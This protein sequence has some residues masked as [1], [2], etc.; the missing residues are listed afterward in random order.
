MLKFR[1][2]QVTTV[3]YEK[4]TMLIIC[5]EW[6]PGKPLHRNSVDRTKHGRTARDICYWTPRLARGLAA[7]HRQLQCRIQGRRVSDQHDAAWRSLCCRRNM[8]QDHLTKRDLPKRRVDLIH[9]E[10][11]RLRPRRRF[12]ELGNC[13]AT[14]HDRM[15]RR[16]LQWQC[17]DRAMES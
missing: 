13:V 16:C 9:A 8:V 5:A 4:Y 14:L 11:E 17:T 15:V 2:G 10:A 6:W 1:H 12:T 7:H 3:K